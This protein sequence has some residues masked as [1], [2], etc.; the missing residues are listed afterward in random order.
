MWSWATRGDFDEA[1][2][3]LGLGAGDMAMLALRA[4]DHLRQVAG[5]KGHETLR[6]AAREA[7]S[8]IIKE[9]VSSPL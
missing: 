9:P 6:K 1:V 4:A 7:I 5:L 3:L 2:E 8:R